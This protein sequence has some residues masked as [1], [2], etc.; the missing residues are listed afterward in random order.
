VVIRARILIEFFAG[1]SCTSIAQKLQLSRNTIAKWRNRFVHFIKE[2]WCRDWDDRVKLSST[3]KVLY[4]APRSGT[5]PKF[6]AKVVCKIMSLAVRKPSDFGRPI[7][8]WALTELTD[9]VIKQEIVE[10]IDR[11]TV[12]R[13][14]QEAD[15][16][17]HK[18]KYWLTPKIDNEEEHEQR[19]NTVCDTYRK[20]I[21]DK[22]TAVY[23]IDEKTGIQALETINPSKAVRAGSP[24]KIEFEYTRHGTLCLTPSFNVQTG[25][26]DIYTIG[27]TRD[28]ND[29]ADHVRKTLEA[30]SAQGKNMVLV[31]DQLNTHKSE[32]LV[33]LFA[34][35]NGITD[36]LGKKRKSGI[37]TSMKSR[38]AFLEDTSHKIRIVYTPKHCSWLNQV[39]IW[40]GVLSRKLLKRLNCKSKDEL[41]KCIEDF[42]QYFNENLAKP[43]Q[44]TYAGKALK[45]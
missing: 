33:K 14:L 26:V 39:E 9:E 16:R 15:I 19:I 31:M 24:E 18:S 4:D 3:I 38:Q 44:W 5:S 23:S 45:K 30:H 20:T 2:E 13:I 17:P 1:K 29:F 34:E 32:S 27:E 43:Y 21:N 11:S 37:L 22:N 10:S 40:F 7:S 36:D 12:G 25:C 6:D 41:R 35:K 42:I 28:E 8:Q